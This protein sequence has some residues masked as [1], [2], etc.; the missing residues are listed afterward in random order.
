ML[1]SWCLLCWNGLRSKKWKIALDW[2]SFSGHIDILTATTTALH[3]VILKESFHDK[4]ENTFF[5][6]QLIYLVRCDDSHFSLLITFL[7]RL[8]STRGKFCWIAAEYLP[9]SLSQSIPSR[10]W[11]RMKSSKSFHWIS[12]QLMVSLGECVP[13]EFFEAV[14]RSTGSTPNDVYYWKYLQC[15]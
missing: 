3:A 14:G 7:F 8:V 4:F 12:S 5:I 2:F 15:W 11:S 6:Q 1:I 10:L 9:P 13:P